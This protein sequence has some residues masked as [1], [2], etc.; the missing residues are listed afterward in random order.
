M[1]QISKLNFLEKR[2]QIKTKVKTYCIKRA[3]SSKAL[4][5]ILVATGAPSNYIK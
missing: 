1:P 5:N 3:S 2:F 4:N